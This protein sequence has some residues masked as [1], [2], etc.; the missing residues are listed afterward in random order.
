MKKEPKYDERSRR[1]H[2][3]GTTVLWAII[4]VD[5]AATHIK[6]FRRLTP[7]LDAEAVKALK[8][9]KFEPGQVNGVAHATPV[10]VEMNFR[11]R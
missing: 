3:E 10:T 4:G 5:G 1:A 9:W 11:L 6:V 7:G 8:A 2:V